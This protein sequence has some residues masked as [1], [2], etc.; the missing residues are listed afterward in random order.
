MNL[1]H[2]YL[3]H[4]H[5][6]THLYLRSHFAK[7]RIRLIGIQKKFCLQKLAKKISNLTNWNFA[8]KNKHVFGFYTINMIQFNIK[9]TLQQQKL[10]THTTCAQLIFSMFVMLPLDTIGQIIS[11]LI[12]APF[13]LLFRCCCCSRSHKIM[14]EFKYNNKILAS[15]K[16][17]YKFYS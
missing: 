7:V 8:R 16:K 11:W 4:I 9:L 13:F 10:S 15:S 1:T 3:E 14:F 5:T 6:R 12:V 17:I 2:L